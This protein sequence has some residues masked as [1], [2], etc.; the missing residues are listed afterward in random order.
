MKLNVKRHILSIKEIRQMKLS[1]INGFLEEKIGFD[2][3]LFPE[4]KEEEYLKDFHLFCI[5][6]T[7][8]LLA[9]RFKTNEKGV[10]S[11][12]CVE[13]ID[14]EYVLQELEYLFLNINKL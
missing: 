13:D 2:W 7:K 4:C 1:Q 14:H 8:D 11:Y 6:I 12:D 5:S 3:E 10:F 9:K